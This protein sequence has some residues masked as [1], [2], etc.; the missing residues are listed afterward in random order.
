MLKGVKDFDNLIAQGLNKRNVWNGI[1][2][3][4]GKSEIKCHQRYLEL[5]SE[6]LTSN[7][8]WSKCE[9]EMITRIVNENGP[10]DW[11]KVAESLPGR[12]GK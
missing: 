10:K 1:S 8:P 6:G 7:R 9:D 11:T 12:I 4:L 5:T 3:R 2:K